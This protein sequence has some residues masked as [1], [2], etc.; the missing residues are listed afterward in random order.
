MA[1][2]R[3]F[4][5]SDICDP[6]LFALSDDALY[7]R[8]DAGFN[9]LLLLLLLL[10]LQHARI[11][12]TDIPMNDEHSGIRLSKALRLLRVSRRR[13]KKRALTEISAIFFFERFTSTKNFA[14]IAAT[15]VPSF[16]SVSR[17]AANRKLS[18]LL[19]FLLLFLNRDNNYM[20]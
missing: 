16:F 4:Y 12:S 10:L 3:R 20:K 2:Y 18:F 14:S 15:Y 7:V 19:G 5:L 1:A 13:R 9:Y 17:R 8:A 6:Y 11:F